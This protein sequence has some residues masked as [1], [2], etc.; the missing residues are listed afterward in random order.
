MRSSPTTTAEARTGTYLAVVR[1]G[2][3]GAGDTITRTFVPDHDVTS[4]TL[5]RATTTRRELL[6]GLL[7]AREYLDPETLE[8]VARSTTMVLDDA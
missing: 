3:V 5:F 7:A 6:P 2:T 8:M 4:G 1:A